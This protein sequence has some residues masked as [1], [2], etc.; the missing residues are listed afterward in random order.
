[1]TRTLC[2]QFKNHTE[3]AGSIYQHLIGCWII[4]KLTNSHYFHI[5][6]TR[7][8][9]AEVSTTE[10]NWEQIFHFL[11]NDS[12]SDKVSQKPF[13]ISNLTD[14]NQIQEDG[15]YQFEFT[16]RALDH[17]FKAFDTTVKDTLREQ[18][19]SYIQYK[20]EKL[21]WNRNK[22]CI[23]IAL[24]LRNSNKNDALFGKNTLPW[25]VFTMNYNNS[26]Q[27]HRFYKWFYVNLLKKI[28][29][30]LEKKNCSYETHIFSQGDMK[31]F[32]S[33]QEVNGIVHL[34]EV[35]SVDAFWHFCMCD[36]LILGKS[37]FSYLASL[38]NPNVKVIRN[39][40]RHQLP[41][42]TIFINDKLEE[43]KGNLQCEI[44]KVLI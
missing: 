12:V 3:G 43:I 7:I 6:P 19:A 9:H 33:F 35:H 22:K 41:S 11:Q 25:E 44:K 37:S 34:D 1:M 16:I 18:F 13:R 30:I 21:L 24:H 8:H 23:K 28:H 14:I 42:E 5:R 17:S 38:L 27:N 2:I 39:G 40:F 31:D 20:P 10:N 26:N 4:S 29:H 15:L 32:E 36:I